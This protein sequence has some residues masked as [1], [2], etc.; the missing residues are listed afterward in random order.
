V[1]NQYELADSGWHFWC[2]ALINIGATGLFIDCAYVMHFDTQLHWLDS[3]VTIQ[4][5]NSTENWGGV[6]EFYANV[7]LE[8]LDHCEWVHLEV[9]DLR[10]NQRVILRL[11]WLRHHNPTIDW[12]SGVICFDKCPPDHHLTWARV[13]EPEEGLIKALNRQDPWCSSEILTPTE[14][15]RSTLQDQ[16]WSTSVEEDMKKSVPPHFGEFRHVFTCVM[17]N[18]LLEH[19]SFD[20]QI[21][22]EETFILQRGKIYHL[23][24]WEQ[25]A[26]DKFLEESLRLIQDYQYLNVHIVWDWYLLPLLCE[27]L[28][29]PKLWTAQ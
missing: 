19:S 3:P 15:L 28:Q 13:A 6:I 22:L 21:N 14:G 4:N 2:T 10:R 9:A 26:L 27:I 18:S 25:R 5:V 16:G 1:N 11:P 20:H 7:F 23:S 12:S 8:T 17:F 24:P 29:A